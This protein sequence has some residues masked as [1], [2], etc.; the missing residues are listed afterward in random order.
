MEKSCKEEWR[1]R[2]TALL[3]RYKSVEEAS[4]SHEE[5]LVINAGLLDCNEKNLSL[6]TGITQM[7][8]N[9]Q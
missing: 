1:R 3:E 5:Q 6:V 2:H 4:E 9:R 7:V 8:V